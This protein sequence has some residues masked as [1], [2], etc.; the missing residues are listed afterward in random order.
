MK[1]LIT[2]ATGLIGSEV[3]KALSQQGHQI[4]IVSRNA[5]RAREMLCYSAEIVE[6]DLS[7]QELP[8]EVFDG[9]AS[10]INLIG[11][12]IDGRWTTQKKKDILDSRRKA[13]EHL[14]KNCPESVKS[15]L[16]ASAVGYYGDRGED[17]VHEESHSGKGFLPEVCREW[18]NAFMNESEKRR[19]V[20]FRLGVVFSR[21]GGALKKM[22]S[23][24]QNQRG[25]RLASGQQWMSWVS[26]P[27][28]VRV[29]CTALEDLHYSG[30][31]NLV[32]P[33]PVTNAE[34]TDML[35]DILGS[36]R[37][38]PAPRSA[39][40]V[41]LGEMSRLLLDSTRVSPRK[42]RAFGYHFLDVDLKT[43]LLKEL[44]P[45]NDAYGFYSAEQFVPGSLSEVFD[46]F[47]DHKNLEK[48][49]PEFLRFHVESI[50]TPEVQEQ[51]VIE[52]KLK[53]HGLPV[54][55]KTLIEVWQPPRHFVDR[56]ISGPYKD[57]QHEHTFTEVPGGV[58]LKDDVRYKLPLGVLG[59]FVAGALLARDIDSIFSYRRKTIAELFWPP[60]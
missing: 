26:L 58:L 44:L 19:V 13:S 56:Q 53:L 59:S 14:L 28:V 36:V 5:A 55:W 40:K 35:C 45:Y 3:G 41:V 57:W 47:S 27:E 43:F 32:S 46:F 51:S 34:L 54:R 49:T 20:I 37:M 60:D 17:I 42:L 7:R 10:I 21:K 18:E 48:L 11:E 16:T 12:S 6:H 25:G 8:P 24:F 2:G 4:R 39:L 29:F 33:E 30:V 15:I 50:S 22:L 1:I 9:V 38:P 23:L 31:V 52:Y